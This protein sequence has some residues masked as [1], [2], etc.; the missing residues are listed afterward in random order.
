MSVATN[1]GSFV[2]CKIFYYYY[3][4]KEEIKTHNGCYQVTGKI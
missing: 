2:S 1:W 3:S 4:F